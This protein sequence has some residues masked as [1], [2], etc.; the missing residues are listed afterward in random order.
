MEILDS[1]THTHTHTY[2]ILDL[3]MLISPILAYTST[4]L[5]LILNEPD[6]YF[7]IVQWFLFQA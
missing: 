4:L 2:T 3:C 6:I 5:N 7:P 1:Y